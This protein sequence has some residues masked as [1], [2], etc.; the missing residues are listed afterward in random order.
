MTPILYN[1]NCTGKSVL[2]T[3]EIICA[4]AATTSGVQ[5]KYSVV[6]LELNQ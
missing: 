6:E 5:W 1:I 2:Y 3:I 4:F